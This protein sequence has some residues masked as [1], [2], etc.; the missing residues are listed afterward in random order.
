MPA[1]ESQ[2]SSMPVSRAAFISAFVIAGPLQK[3]RVPGAVRRLISSLESG[4]AVATPTSTTLSSMFPARA[5]ALMAAPP[6][7]KFNT[8]C[9]VTSCGYATDSFRADSVIRREEYDSRVA[10]GQLEAL[11]NGGATVGDLF[12]APKASRRLGEFQLTAACGF[13]PCLDRLAGSCWIVFSRRFI[14]VSIPGPELG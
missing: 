9:A 7:R 3:L 12:K 10:G 13:D 6:R 5:S 2:A 14:A 1:A 4:S 8:I 11:S